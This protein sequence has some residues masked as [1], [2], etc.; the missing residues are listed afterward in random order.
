MIATK[1]LAVRIDRRVIALAVFEGP[2]VQHSEVRQLPSGSARAESAVSAFISRIV[3]G[4]SP[5]SAALEI[6]HGTTRRTMFTGQCVALLR[7]LG[8][9]V[10]EVPPADLLASYG[11]PP[12]VNRLELR[13]VAANLWPVISE[14]RMTG[15]VQ[16]AL[17]LGLLVQTDRLLSECEVYP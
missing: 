7:G 17:A 12:L 8:I 5:H 2:E 1:L 9:P 13:R 16:D 15:F 6:V 11:Y 3:Q 14:T 10:T 4:Y